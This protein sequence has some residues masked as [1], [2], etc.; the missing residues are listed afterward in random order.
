MRL[1]ARLRPRRPSRDTTRR[2]LPPAVSVA[3]HALLLVLIV[4][5]GVADPL[6]PAQRPRLAEIAAAP[7]ARSP[8]AEPD[9]GPDVTPPDPTRARAHTPA[10][11]AAPTP[12]S[13]LPPPAPVEPGEPVDA[14][15]PPSSS[16]VS[17]TDLTAPG[18]ADSPTLS[19]AGLTAHAA[20]R[21]VYVVDA[22]GAVV[23][24]LTYIKQNLARS[25]DRLAPTQRFEIIFFR[26]PVPGAA[27]D[28]RPRFAG[29]LV[30]A[31]ASTRARAG[32]WIEEQTAAGRSDPAAALEDAIALDPD[33]IF[34][35]S[36]SIQRTQTDGPDDKP[37]LL[38]R[39]DELNPVNPRTGLRP[40]V[41]KTLQFLR[42]DPANLLR[43]I[44]LI[45]GDGE[46]SYRLLT[47]DRL[48]QPLDTG[49]ETAPDAPALDHAARALQA[50]DADAW[51]TLLAFPT[52]EQRDRVRDAASDALDRLEALPEPG[53]S[54]RW[55]L[56]HQ[57]ASL[58][59][60]ASSGASPTRPPLRDTLRLARTAPLT[61]PDADLERR[62]VRALARAVLDQ[63]S[64]LSELSAQTRSP[65]V[66]LR[67]ALGARLF[68]D[69]DAA[70]PD[71]PDPRAL[72]LAAQSHARARLTT[73]PDDPDAFAPLL[74]LAGDPRL[75]PEP[76]LR[77]RLVHEAV[78]AAEDSFDLDWNAVAPEAALA[79]ATHRS[80]FSQTRA[81]A[82]AALEQ[83][84][85]RDDAPD[86]VRAG[87]LW[88]AAIAERDR[89]ETDANARDRVR[90]RL[91]ALVT[92]FPADINAPLAAA[93]A[94]ALGST[95]NA[96]LDPELPSDFVRLALDTFPD[97]PAADRWHLGLARR[98]SGPARLDLL[99][100]IPPDSPETDLALALYTD[101]AFSLPS[102]ETLERALAYTR[103][104]ADARWYPLALQ[105]A[106]TLVTQADP[107]PED[108]SR[109]A[110]L[111]IALSEHA[112]R[113]V[114][115]DAHELRFRA[116]A[117]LAG[118]AASDPALAPR[119][120]AT[121]TALAGDLESER[122]PLFWHA[123][124]LALETVAAHA[125]AS[126][127]ARSDARAHLARLRLLDPDLGAEPWRSRLR[128][129]GESLDS[130]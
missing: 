83:L 101:T 95:E 3:V 16:L 49:P 21:I 18:S 46:T 55:A 23:P 59:Y 22:S 52:R 44:A 120:I 78:A 54:P 7:A 63:P 124:T 36:T 24:T 111:Y 12:A 58:F 92:R 50:V 69:H 65:S 68:G 94:V 119:A 53:R 81:P 108:A 126:D 117:A 14:V 122:T 5:I 33:L 29:E 28:P 115:P 26:E 6:P 41:I 11:R 4:L 2:A 66:A 104:R 123:W 103:E 19:F 37:R 51:T 72:L 20:E 47:A 67:A 39:L 127:P 125:P 70:L 128:D 9:P 56:L 27:L 86:T 130:P 96:A 13:L 43:D 100:R 61:D 15:L 89:A 114:N 85:R 76:T 57:R 116:G 30:S 79:R 98:A 121:L 32:E 25:I 62:L 17:A 75:H 88:R 112:D 42:P 105:L 31:T 35:L 34:L 106:D 74:A 109:A 84:A 71:E 91:M 129:A 80:L 10:P 99:D 45:H 87:A 38:Q 60:S 77:D 110:D 1:P 113:I 102:P 118:G 90:K 8:V 73:A 48:D 97:H 40:V 107:A 64:E 82:L 93:A